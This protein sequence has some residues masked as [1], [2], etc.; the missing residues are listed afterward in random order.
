MSPFWFLP[1][2]SPQPQGLVLTAYQLAE[3][4]VGVQEIPGREDNP[5]VL[6]MLKLD[7]DW[8]ENDEVAWCSAF[9]NYVAWLL[10]LPRSKSLRA[11]TWLQVGTPVIKIT[12]A[13]VGFD[14]VVLKRGGGNQP[15][16]EVIN[17]TGHVGFFAGLDGGK[18]LLLGGNQQNAVGVGEYDTDRI[19][20]TRRLWSPGIEIG[21]PN[22]SN[23][24]V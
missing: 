7:A 16:P 8:P 15:G 12:D 6:A 24:G 20:G 10:R 4:F 18:V 23:T 22:A 14:V 9:V 21:T 11:R 5:Q 19:L 17:A 3:R 1:P 13:R 2:P